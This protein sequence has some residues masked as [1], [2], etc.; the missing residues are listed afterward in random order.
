[1]V[2]SPQPVQAAKLQQS[3]IGQVSLCVGFIKWQN[4]ESFCLS[5]LVSVRALAHSCSHCGQILNTCGYL[6][7]WDSFC[8]GHRGLLPLCAVIMFLRHLLY[9]LQAS[10]RRRA[11]SSAQ[12]CMVA[13]G[14][15]QEE[16]A[17]EC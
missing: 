4:W 9:R 6:F 16:S 11:P 7:S 10:G 14:R 13:G 5:W 8:L 2:A 15:G 3:F 17:G 1:M 12:A